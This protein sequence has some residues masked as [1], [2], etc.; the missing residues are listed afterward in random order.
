MENQTLWQ[1]I[2][3]WGKIVLLAIAVFI[4]VKFAIKSKNA[5]AKILH[6]FGFKDDE[7]NSQVTIDHFQKVDTGNDKS[8]QTKDFIASMKNKYLAGNK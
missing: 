6:F 3:F 4:I 2:K 8:N 7:I 5:I 1:R